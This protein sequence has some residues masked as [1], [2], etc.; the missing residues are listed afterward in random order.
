MADPHANLRRRRLLSR[1]VL[2]ALGLTALFVGLADAPAGADTSAPVGAKAQEARSLAQEAC[3]QM[4]HDAIVSEL[5]GHP[6]P[7]PQ[8]GIWQGARYTCTYPLTGGQFVMRVDT[9]ATPKLARRAYASTLKKSRGQQPLDGIGQKAFLAKN[10]QVVSQKD[11]FVLT[12]DP[13]GVPRKSQRANVALAAA[14]AVL[15]CWAGTN[16]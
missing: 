7:G 14:E 9:F 3:E 12:A 11:L 13:A 1:R 15:S 4:V 2:V 6:L 10:G 8:T 5:G 16:S